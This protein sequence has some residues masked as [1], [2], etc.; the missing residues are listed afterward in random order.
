MSGGSF[1]NHRWHV[2]LCVSC[3]RLFECFCEAPGSVINYQCA[4]CEEEAEIKKE[5]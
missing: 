4:D 3:D 1:V 5:G 2:H